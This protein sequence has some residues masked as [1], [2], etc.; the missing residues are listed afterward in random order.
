MAHL[1]CASECDKE[2]DCIAIETNGWNN[3]LGQLGPCYL[4]TDSGEEEIINGECERGYNIRSG[5]Q[6][7]FKK[8]DRGVRYIFFATLNI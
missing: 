2:D 8:E 1:D 3:R 4:F 5:D 6:K 7:C